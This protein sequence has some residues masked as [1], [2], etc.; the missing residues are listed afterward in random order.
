MWTDGG[1]PYIAALVVVDSSH[2]FGTARATHVV[3]FYSDD[4]ELIGSVADF[5]APAF[6][7]EHG[8]LVV[9][10]DRHRLDLRAELRMRGIDLAAAEKF[11]RALGLDASATLRTILRAGS[12]DRDAFERVIGGA[13]DKVGAGS[14]QTRVYGELVSLLWLRGDAHGAVALEDAW[15]DLLARRG[16]TLLCGYPSR[17]LGERA[18]PELLRAITG[19]HGQISPLGDV[20]PRV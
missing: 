20:R 15:N 16:I 17:V 9:A 18:R 8:V 19:A 3:H 6:D 7:A 14:G 4:A 13:I 10:T 1:A 11:G 2:P 5:L 12:L